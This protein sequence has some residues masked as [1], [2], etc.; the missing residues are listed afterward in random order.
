MTFYA[1][2]VLEN[3][4]S[5]EKFPTATYWNDTKFIATSEV[6]PDLYSDFG[7]DEILSND[8]IFIFSPAN[9]E[10]CKEKIN[11]IILQ[12]DCIITN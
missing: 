5:K 2:L 10:K 7:N 1:S 3:R 11:S 8:M 4:N 12:I 6:L 9:Q